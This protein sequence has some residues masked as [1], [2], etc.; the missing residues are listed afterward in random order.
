[1]RGFRIYPDIVLGGGRHVSLATR[2]APHDHAASDLSCDCRVFRQRER[3]VG[4]RTQS[5]EYKPRVRLD[6]VD[7]CVDRVQL[8][9]RLTG[10]RIV[11]ISEPVSTMK[12]SRAL[13]GS[14]QWLAGA[15]IDRHFGSAEFDGI[16]RIAGGL[17]NCDISGNRCD[18]DH[19]DFWSAE[20]HD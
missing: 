18:R 11:V 6:G 20:S 2:G 3:N 16:K 5:H 14:M 10:R 13:M 1:M 7:H 19:A 12:P 8:S 17:L 9:G 4:E 15:R